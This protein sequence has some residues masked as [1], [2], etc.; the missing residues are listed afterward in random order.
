MKLLFTSAFALFL[1]A[2][3][4]SS[5]TH[6]ATIPPHCDTCCD[7]CHT[8]TTTHP[9]DT[10]NIDKDSAAHAFE[11][12]QY[13]VPGEVSITGVWVFGPNDIILNGGTLW[14]FDGLTF[15]KID[16]RNATHNNAALSGV[17]SGA[18]IFA[19]TQTEFWIVH[20]AVAYHTT[21]GQYFDDYRAGSV[22]ACWGSAP[23]DV[24]IVGNG[25]H[26]AHFDGTKFTD[27]N[28]GTIEDIRSIWGTSHNN[29][30]A[31]GTTDPTYKTVI[32]HYD[33]SNWKVDN[34]SNSTLANESSLASVWTADSTTHETVITAGAYVFRKTDNTPWRKDIYVPNKLPDS[35]YLPIGE[36]T[37]NNAN[38]LW[39]VGWLGWAGHWNGKTWMRYDNLYEPSNDQYTSRAS[40]VKDNTI[41]VVGSKNGKSWVA[42]GTRK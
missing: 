38:D 31:C 22:N 36:L 12:K 33:G 21:D 15:T 7:T 6:Y 9:C 14:H 19:F 35:T 10:C 32:T 11:W 40:S 27:M 25:G 34:L 8:D 39:S 24:F 20:S 23:N 17:L 16:A 42:I 2:G 41:C 13:N 30:W 26:I 18:S 5:C 3:T 4:F 28:S 37:G 1:A 29:I